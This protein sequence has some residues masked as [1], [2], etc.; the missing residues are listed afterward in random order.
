TKH[1]AGNLKAEALIVLGIDA[2]AYADKMN[3]KAHQI[4][5]VPPVACKAGCAWCSSMQVLVTAPEVFCLAEWLRETQSEEELARVKERLS[6]QWEQVK[7]T[8]MLERLLAGVP[9]ALLRDADKT[10]SV[11]E[12]R[13]L[14]CRG[15][16]SLDAAAC[17]AATKSKDVKVTS[18]AIQS[19]VYNGIGICL[20]VGMRDAGLRPATYEL[21][22]ALLY[23]LDHPEA[24][25]RWAAGED[26]FRKEVVRPSDKGSVSSWER[27]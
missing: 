5:S 12:A 25:T 26:V 19:H 13:P 17:E 20:L 4:K 6:A 23:C 18:D 9:C 3:A 27:Q 1:L 15:H 14:A 16:T 11:Y 22:G 8:P 2:L 10:C 21:S 7:G 24:A